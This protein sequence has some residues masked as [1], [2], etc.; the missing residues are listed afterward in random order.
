MA[1]AESV[2]NVAIVGPNGTGKTTLLESLLFVTGAIGRKGKAGGEGNTVGDASPE[3]RERQMSVEVNA[4]T[5]EH[6]GMTLTFLDCPGA[7]DFAQ[8]ARN[9]LLGVDAAV[10]VVEPVLERMITV[11]PLLKYLDA[12]QIPHL[13]FINKMDRAEVAYRDLLQSLRDL[14]DRPGDPPS[15][16][17]RPQ[18]RP[19]RLHRSRDR[20][21]LQLQRRRALGPD[22]SARG[23]PRARAGGAHRDARDARRL[24]RRPDGDAARGAGAAGRGDPAPHAEDARRRPGRAG[25]HGRGRARHGGQAPARGADQGDPAALGEPRRGSASTPPARR[26]S[27]CSRTIICPMPASSAWSGSGPARSRTA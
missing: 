2:R 1:A 14:S 9:A 24:R 17:D 25:V 27:R 4:A 21:G 26:W 22:R 16:R 23:V 15:I 10:V 3:A 19:D 8:E 13:I 18:R 12:R 7:V 5:A 6:D 11:S 20:A